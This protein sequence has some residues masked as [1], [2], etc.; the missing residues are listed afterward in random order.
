MMAAGTFS[1]ALRLDPHAI[2]G[3]LVVLCSVVLALL[4]RSKAAAS[5]LLFA[6]AGG[7]RLL[8]V[9]PASIS[10]VAHA[11]LAQGLL[12]SAFLAALETSPGWTKPSPL[13]DG[14]FPSLRQLGFLMPAVTLLQIGLGAAYRRELAGAVPHI[15]WAFATAICV[16]MAGTFVLTQKES[17]RLLRGI[18]VWLLGLTG[19]Q[20]LLGVGAYLARLNPG[21]G[22]L[23]FISTAHITTG[24]LVMALSTAWSAVV[25]RDTR[26]SVQTLPIQT[27]RPS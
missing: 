25:R 17:G 5:A 1:S 13:E 16:M 24:S 26:L 22:W 12:A 9:A 10:Q 7:L 2:L 15:S 8:A 27:G 3:G 19:I 14:G 18:S 6:L 21:E 4:H 11:I 20:L 23:A